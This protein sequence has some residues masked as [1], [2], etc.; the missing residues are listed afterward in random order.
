MGMIKKI[1][2]KAV[3]LLRYINAQK[4]VCPI[5]E[6]Q[7]R[8]IIKD[9]WLRDNYRCSRCHS[10]PR[11]RALID[12]I[13]RFYPDFVNL[14][15]HESSPNKGASSAFLRNRCK[16]YS[17]SQYLED[18]PRGEFKDGVRSEDLSALTFEDNTIDLL[19]T[20]DVFEHVMEPE[21]AFREIAR[22]L[23][24]G[25]AHIFSMPWYPRFKTTI[26]RAKIENGN[27]NYLQ[28]AVYHSNPVDQQ[29]GALVT[30]DWGQDFVDIIYR[31]SGLYTIIYLQKDRYKGLD[32]EFLEIFISKKP[33]L[34]E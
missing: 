11:Y 17:S 19:I 5:C 14:I 31:A 7:V 20:Q 30:F 33:A 8:F 27:I 28:E 26:Q 25:G 34:N 18:V 6:Q 29:K 21:K 4:G 12:T 3:S 10:I 2:S 32:G 1:R 15:V 23:K 16:N 24:P 9:K 22:V 13:K